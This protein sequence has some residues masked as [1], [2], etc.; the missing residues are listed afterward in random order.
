[1]TLCSKEMKQRQKKKNNFKMYQKLCSSGLVGHFWKNFTEWSQQ[2]KCFS[3][4]YFTNSN[5]TWHNHRISLA[6]WLILKINESF[7]KRRSYYWRGKIPTIPL[8]LKPMI[9]H[10]KLHL[11]PKLDF[12]THF[13]IISNLNIE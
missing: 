13:K 4:I 5:I 6:F 3:F 12:K 1:M 11:C 8:G 9:F 10:E 7:Q 2:A